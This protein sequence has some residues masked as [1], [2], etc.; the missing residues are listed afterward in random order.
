[1]VQSKELTHFFE[2][3]DLIKK[4]P[5]QKRGVLFLRQVVP[6]IKLGKSSPLEIMSLLTEALSLI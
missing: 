4:C 2:K 5:L 1:M 6:K 3:A